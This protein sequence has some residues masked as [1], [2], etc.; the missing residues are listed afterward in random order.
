MRAEL[1][2]QGLWGLFHLFNKAKLVKEQ[3]AQYMS[4]WTMQA[5]NGSPVRVRFKV[6]ADR[7][8]N[9]FTPGLMQGLAMPE[10]LASV[11]PKRNTNL[12]IKE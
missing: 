6:K 11:K 12:A 8:N 1:N 3:G 2:S 10:R 5:A 4:V 7:F 9:V